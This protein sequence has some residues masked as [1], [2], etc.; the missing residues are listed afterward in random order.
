MFTNLAQF[1]LSGIGRA[2]QARLTVG[3]RTD[4]HQDNHFAVNPHRARR[5]ALVCHWQTVPSTGA[6]ECVWRTAKPW[7]TP[8]IAPTGSSADALA[9]VEP[10]LLRPAA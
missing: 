3:H 8:L 6:I 7:P 9:I 2:Q 1:R 4:G 10:P 5:T